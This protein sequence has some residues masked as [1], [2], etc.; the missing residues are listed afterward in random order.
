MKKAP[1]RVGLSGFYIVAVVLIVQREL[2]Y[3]HVVNL[4]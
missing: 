4:L 2:A 3:E 1:L